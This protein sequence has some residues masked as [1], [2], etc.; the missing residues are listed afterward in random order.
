[1]YTRMVGARLAPAISTV[2]ISTPSE[3]ARGSMASSRL[4]SLP[5][6][7]LASSSRCR[8]F[9]APARPFWPLQQKKAGHAHFLERESMSARLFAQRSIYTIYGAQ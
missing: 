8:L 3:A 2:T 1:M 5:V 7:T 4:F 6:S 9:A